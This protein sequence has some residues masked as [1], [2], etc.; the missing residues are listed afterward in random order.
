MI[1]IY[2]FRLETG[3]YIIQSFDKFCF[4]LLFSSYDK[5]EL[6]IWMDL[7]GLTYDKLMRRNN[8]YKCHYRYYFFRLKSV[9]NQ[10]GM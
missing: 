10:Y 2:L 6:K 3:K 4:K 1:D 5:Y 9:N 7:N 8:S